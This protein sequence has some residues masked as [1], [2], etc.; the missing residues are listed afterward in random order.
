MQKFFTETVE[1]N[2]IKAILSASP[3][4]IF[5]PVSDG[6]YIVKGCRYVY[7]CNLIFCTKS[8]YLN[9]TD[10]NIAEYNILSFMG[11][12]PSP[13]NEYDVFKSTDTNYDSAAHHRLGEYLRYVSHTSGI[14]LM[15]FYNCFGYNQIHS[16]INVDYGTEDYGKYV[17]EDNPDFKIFAI[18]IKF[19]KQYTIAIDSFTPI[20]LK[21]VITD[22]IGLTQNP[23]KETPEDRV[24]SDLSDY[25]SERFPGSEV[26]H[27][28]LK[29][30]RTLFRQPFLYSISN[31]TAEGLSQ[32]QETVLQ[33]HEKDLYLIL[34]IS[35]SNNSSIVVLEGDYREYRFYPFNAPTAFFLHT[36]LSELKLLEKNDKYCY[37][38]SDKLVEYLA[39]AVISPA[40]S[41][42]EN[43]AK[44]NRAVLGNVKLPYEYSEEL[45]KEVFKKVLENRY[46]DKFDI[47]GYV[48]VNAEKVISRGDW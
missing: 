14:N 36:G 37:A 44:A 7:A 12:N 40:D 20:Y 27:K 39:S 17:A 6:D 9:G 35:R 15:P 33:Q 34:Q 25:L 28:V 32:E 30:A 38:F 45:K 5:P 8:G 18:P 2:F 4:S 10:D 23:L 11:N 46:S 3:I 16:S 13:K 47:D 22:D 24:I 41:I 26:K 1:S 31:K 29:Y 21:A 43:I 48:D 19:N 42:S